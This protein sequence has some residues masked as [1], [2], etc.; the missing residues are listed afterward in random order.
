MEKERNALDWT[1]MMYKKNVTKI[2]ERTAYK[3]DLLNDDICEEEKDLPRE[4]VI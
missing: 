3:D 2:A 4:L 1:I